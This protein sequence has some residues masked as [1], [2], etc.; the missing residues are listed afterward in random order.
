[1]GPDRMV[2]TI[3]MALE[4]KCSFGSDSPVSLESSH[5]QYTSKQVWMAMASAALLTEREQKTKQNKPGK[6][7]QAGSMTPDKDDETIHEGKDSLHNLCWENWTFM[8]TK[9]RKRNA[10]AQLSSSFFIQSSS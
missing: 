9:S 4:V 3:S 10:G 8:W 6:S 5:R 1:M 7:S 2:K